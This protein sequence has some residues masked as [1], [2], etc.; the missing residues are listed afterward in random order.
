MT[1]SSARRSILINTLWGKANILVR[2]LTS[3]VATA[4]IAANYSPSDFGLY[5]LVLTYFGIIES[6]NLLNPTHL[7]NFLIQDPTKE[8]EVSSLWMLQSFFLWLFSSL[9]IL[10]FALTLRDSVFWWL[11]LVVNI[12]GFFRIFDF[13]QVVADFRLR[14]ELTQSVHIVMTACFNVFRLVFAVLKVN[15]FVLSSAMVVQGIASGLYQLYVKG[16]L[17]YKLKIKLPKAMFFSLF[18]GGF[19]LSVVA[20]LG[21]VQGRIVAALLADRMDLAAYGNFQLI[22]KLIEP[23]TAIGSI[24]IG[25]NY[26][27]LSHTLKEDVHTFHKRF[28]KVTLLAMTTAFLCGLVIVAFPHSLLIRIFGEAYREGI[29]LLWMGVG[30]LIANT[31]LTVTVQ[32][33]M[34]KFQYRKVVIKYGAIFFLYIVYFSFD[35]PMTLKGVLIIQSFV[36]VLVVSAIGVIDILSRS[37]RWRS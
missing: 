24:V 32:I 6:I 7:R 34:M 12:R 4:V 30:I 21:A 14:N 22:L 16:K 5:Q 31:I 10:V 1:A 23:A 15:L 3:F 8:N 36:P 29:S 18:K 2:Y 17:E 26:T 33:D 19:A 13:V 37:A 11:L 27:V 28:F 35:Q 20:F 25:A 9:V